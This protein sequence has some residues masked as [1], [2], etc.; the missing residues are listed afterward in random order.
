MICQLGFEYWQNRKS[1]DKRIKGAGIKE[2]ENF[3]NDLKK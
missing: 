2:I 1:R 3:W